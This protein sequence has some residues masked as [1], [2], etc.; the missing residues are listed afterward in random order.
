MQGH[1]FQVELL[2]RLLGAGARVVEEP[3]RFRDREHGQTKLGIGSSLEFFSNVWRLRLAS[4]RTFIKFALVGLTGVFVN[5]GSFHL[6][7]EIGVHEFLASPIA[8]E[9]SIISNFLLDNFWTFA[10][11]AMNGRKRLR[12]LKFNLVSLLALVPSYATFVGLS[13]LFPHGSPVLLQGCGIVPGALV[14]YF[15]SSCWT[16]R[17]VGR[18]DGG[19]V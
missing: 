8:I 12:G 1:A 10:D 15:L 16:F 19:R 4:H 7:L 14:N 5:L 6:L 18:E 3:I 11:R 17:E 13:M 2:H 9:L